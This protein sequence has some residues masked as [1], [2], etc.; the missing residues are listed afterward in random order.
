MLDKEMNNENEA[1]NGTEE[2]AQPESIE[3]FTADDTEVPY[4]PVFGAND[5]DDDVIVVTDADDVT[6]ETEETAV[7]EA[8]DNAAETG[9]EP[10][11]DELQC[12]TEVLS[13]DNGEGDGAVLTETEV[14]ATSEK[15]KTSAEDDGIDILPELKADEASM[16]A[17]AQRVQAQKA[18]T[19]AAQT[20]K[21][22][23]QKTEA[24][25]AGAG[26]RKT[27]RRRK[28]K[29]SAGKIVAICIILVVYLLSVTGL[30]VA[31]GLFADDSGL[32]G[33]I[34]PEKEDNE[35]KVVV[36]T[37]TNA[38]GE[39]ETITQVLV[40]DENKQKSFNFLVLGHNSMLTDVFM[41]VNIDCATSNI[42]IMQ[43]PRDT[44]IADN[45][46]KYIT[47]NKINAVLPTY[48]NYHRATEKTEDAYRK[49][50]E[51]VGETI[52]NNLGITI[53]FTV[54]MDLAGFR[55]IVDALGGVEIYV[56]QGLYYEDPAQGLYI[57][58]PSGYQTLNGAQA[59][60]FVRFRKGY[61]TADLGRQ[62]AQKQFL[63]A[64]LTKVKS[65]LSITN[66]SQLT[67]I[68]NEV[69]K[70]VDTDMSVTDMI[71]FAKEIIKCNPSD[72]NMLTMPGN[73][74]N[75]WYVMNREAVQMVLS[76]NYYRYDGD[77]PDSLFDP[78][79]VFNCPWEYNMNYVYNLPADQ[80]YDNSVWNGENAGDI[81]IPRN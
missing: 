44:W 71:Y 4:V 2:S 8:E 43:I 65:S 61:T 73:L 6:A 30:V 51:S 23:E 68:A 76:Q 80:V 41:L 12:E 16:M 78:D 3:L 42:T 39:I 58:I 46:G 40:P 37:Y 47:T 20:P 63:A 1:V 70:N 34:M 57:N 49:A 9:A 79:Q 15:E 52:E 36:E 59:E 17:L 50:Y 29:L 53:D 5:A 7:P 18:K 24:A 35:T 72:M 28:N 21:P 81:H 45:N 48:Y 54:I 32:D 77:I 38:D 60:G 69:L 14:A 55:G 26:A 10:L 74:A 25:G 22:A 11:F 75:G 27:V 33:L 56:E 13:E 62:N 66:V 64:L 67:K 31:Y 19:Q